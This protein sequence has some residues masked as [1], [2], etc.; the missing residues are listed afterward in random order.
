MVICFLSIFE[1]M[2]VLASYAD[3]EDGNKEC[4][5]FVLYNLLRM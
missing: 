2:Q 1:R 4:N 3:E 5:L